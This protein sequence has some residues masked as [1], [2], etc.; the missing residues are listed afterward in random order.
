MDTINFFS[1]KGGVGRTFLT[2]QVSRCLAA[3]G[4]NVVVADF[5]FDAP[6]IPGI[7]E[8]DYENIKGGI[9][10][11]VL[12]YVNVSE[13]DV[14]IFKEFKRQLID[15][16]IPIDG[17]KVLNIPHNDTKR[18]PNGKG[19]LHILPN[20]HL[21]QSYM[22][23]V[24]S[25]QWLQIVGTDEY[26]KLVKNTNSLEGFINN[27][28][29][30]ALE[31][32]KVDYF[33]IDSS[34]GVTQCGGVSRTVSNRH[35]MIVQSNEETKYALKTFL[36]PAVCNMKLKNLA[37]FVFVISRIP[38]EYIEKEHKVFNDMKTFIS[39]N[40][41]K[42]GLTEETISE[43]IKFVKLSSD[44]KLHY[45][46]Q[47]RTI[48]ERYLDY[49]VVKEGKIEI[50]NLHE[51][52]FSILAGLCPEEVPPVAKNG[53]LTEQAHALWEKI[54]GYSFGINSE[55]KL[56]ESSDG[57]MKNIDDK[58]R[59]VALKVE[60][61]SDLLREVENL[62]GV[63]FSGGEKFGEALLKQWGRENRQYD[64]VEKIKKWCEFDS[65]A[66]FG[67]MEFDGKSIITIKNAFVVDSGTPEESQ[68]TSF[69]D[70]YVSGV[71]KQL[72]LSEK[73]PVKISAA[74]PE[75]SKDVSIITYNVEY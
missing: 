1:Y 39:E 53:K 33:V 31:S 56:F 45:D 62:Q 70:G 23:D 24:S 75:L 10:E 2:M 37:S 51:D 15:F 67:K 18:D 63:G 49:Q 17:V 66:G 73:P 30:P 44:I 69:L 42:S 48:D 57:E 5:D 28:I 64:L 47:I 3:L 19:E 22:K 72:G 68:Q 7:F 29:K 35:A 65:R 38:A 25:P 12:E 20:G 52:V 58:N 43:R 46:P 32:L 9:R 13:S 71:L 50:V 6:G 27:A 36:L 74:R 26:T 34:A 40:L 59:N 54:F 16:M 61:L 14:D 21:T 55:N 8:Y 41:I 4:K 60:T 11:L